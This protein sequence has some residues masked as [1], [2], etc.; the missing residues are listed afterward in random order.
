MLVIEAVD[1]AKGFARGAFLL[2][3]NATCASFCFCVRPLSE[4]PSQVLAAGADNTTS[5]VLQRCAGGKRQAFCFE[6]SE[7]S[8]PGL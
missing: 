1:K 7:V 6:H 4:L 2:K 5:L 8:A 3:P